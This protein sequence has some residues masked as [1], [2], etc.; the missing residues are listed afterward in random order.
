ME[1]NNL[2]NIEISIENENYK[3]QKSKTVEYTMNYDEALCVLRHFYN[4]TRGKKTIIYTVL[5][6]LLSI[7]FLITYFTMENFKNNLFVAILCIAVL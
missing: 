3:T 6:S 7:F 2:E 1:E 5:L 4:K